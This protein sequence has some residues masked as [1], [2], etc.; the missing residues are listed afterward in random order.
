MGKSDQLVDDLRSI[1][2]DARKTS[3]HVQ[4]EA[5]LATAPFV[6]KGATPGRPHE[7]AFMRDRLTHESYHAICDAV[8]R[9][10]DRLNNEIARL[11][12]LEKLTEVVESAQR[13]I[14]ATPARMT[15][16]PAAYRT[17]GPAE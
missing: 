13:R 6:L 11:K 4:A 2:D 17:P 1:F 15:T 5:L 3:G 7:V 16:P 8:G 14:V 10:I 12:R 9:E